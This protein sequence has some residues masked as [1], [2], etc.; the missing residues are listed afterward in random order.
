MTAGLRV[1]LQHGQR[2]FRAQ[3]ADDRDDGRVVDGELRVND[4]VRDAVLVVEGAH[5]IDFVESRAQAILIIDRAAHAVGERFARAAEWSG[6]RA[7]DA[8]GDGRIIWHVDRRQRSERAGAGEELAARDHRVSVNEASVVAK[9]ATENAMLVTKIRS[10]STKMS[11][12]I[13]IS[14][15]S[16]TTST[17]ASAT[18]A[19]YS[20]PA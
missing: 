18:P 20:R 3:V 1:R 10:L 5:R 8:D 11:L 16:Y 13:P 4:C 9:N 17:A 14:R 2:V 19:K 12:A 7:H 15:S 6:E